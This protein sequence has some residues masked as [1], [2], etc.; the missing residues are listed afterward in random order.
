MEKRSISHKSVQRSIDEL[1]FDLPIITPRSCVVGIDTTYFSRNFGVTIFRDITNKRTLHWR[2]VHRENIQT[3]I[4]G[5]EYLEENGI[6][7]LGFVVDGFWGFYVRYG[8]T[9]DIQMCQKHMADIVRRHITL[10]PKLE[11]SRELK[12][13]IDR[14]S[15]ISEHEFNSKFD[16]WLYRWGNF[17]KERTY[18]DEGRW[19]YTHG[20]LRSAS[21]SLIKY[22]DYLFTHETNHWLPNTNNSIEG[23]NS[24]LKSAIKLHRGS[25]GERK[26]KLIH[27]YLKKDSL[28]KWDMPATQNVL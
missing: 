8:N 23:F 26:V 5:V 13:I 2:F 27:L 22:H 6:T 19:F 25:K 16:N 11:A 17:L 9:Y 10:K 14:L 20:R 12:E 4:K 18:T 7:I 24:D 21:A 28:L 1:T 3:H 15:G